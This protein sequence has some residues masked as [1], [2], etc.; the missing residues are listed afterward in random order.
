MAR[1]DGQPMALIAAVAQN[2]AIGRA[3]GLPWHISGDLKFFK[4]KTLGKPVIMGRKT[5]DSI[6]RPLP[7][8]P[9]IVITR[10]PKFAAEG[11]EVV[12]D[13]DGATALAQRLAQDTGAE[14]IMVIGGAEIYAQAMP[15]AD[16]LYITEVAASPEGDAFFPEI[17]AS[18]WR[19]SFREA[20]EGGEGPG[21]CFVILERVR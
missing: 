21:Y 17:A 5:Y 1:P 7:G 20:H 14:E 18:A 3:G 16:R 2:G 8:R 13:L 6:G 4:A 15:S 9:N 11:V 12:R 19:E 10:N